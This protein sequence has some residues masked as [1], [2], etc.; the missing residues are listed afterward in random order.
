METNEL[1]NENSSTKQ[2][3]NKNNFVLLG[4][5]GALLLGSLG[6][7][8]YQYQQGKKAQVQSDAL[9]VNLKDTE[10]AKVILQQELDL[11]TEE[12]EQTK[13]EMGEKDS[14][15]SKRDAEIYDKQK[16]IQR[17]LSKSNVTESEL[18][19]AQRMIKSL[20]SDIARFK[21][22]I[23]LLKEVN[24]SLTFANDTLQYQQTQLTGELV[25][26][27]QKAEETESKMRSTF[28]VSNYQ[29]TG[30]KVR[31]SGKEVETTR[32]KRIDKMR[33]NFDLD[34]NQWAESG[35]YEV[36]IAI[37]KPDGSLGKFNNADPG[38]LE[39]W[40]LGTI[41]YSDKV[42][43]NYTKGATK[44]ITFDWEGYDF[45]KGIYKIDLYQNGLKIGQKSLELR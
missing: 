22:E 34:P 10:G 23:A 44:N 21:Q 2:P 6:F 45:P 25:Q 37:Y 18:K 41:S 43:F 12:F 20:N 15:L 42:S 5:L 3:S 19:Q 39:T 35:Q 17:I 24:D 13:L 8:I 16:E 26:Q 36:Y 30:L 4:I 28:S 9:A 27:T 7:N 32:A 40:S 11:L 14:L 33:V 31:N 1:Q 29:I 38:Q